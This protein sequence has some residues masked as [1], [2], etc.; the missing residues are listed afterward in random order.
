MPKKTFALLKS[1]LSSQKNIAGSVA[2]N[3][4]KGEN[5]KLN[6]K[7]ISILLIALMLA[8]SG[9]GKDEDDNDD[10]ALFSKWKVYSI[11]AY[12]GNNSNG[13]WTHDGTLILPNDYV[14]TFEF[15]SNNTYIVTDGEDTETGNY[16]IVG[17]TI[18]L[19]DDADEHYSYVI[20]GNELTL[21]NIY[22]DEDE[23][24]KDIIVL[25]K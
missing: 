1:A 8:F 22:F 11:A 7:M 4:K 12:Y 17:D 19:D 18:I 20:N 15:K 3:Q 13:P 5:M 25:K 14:V 6:S 24:Y 9:C 23:W 2:C 16:E 21:T 10:N